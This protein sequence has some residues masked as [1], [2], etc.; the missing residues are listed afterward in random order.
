MNVDLPQQGDLSDPTARQC[1]V[2]AEPALPDSATIFELVANTAPV[3]I[4]V[5]GPDKLCRAA[6][7]AGIGERLGGWCAL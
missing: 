7:R 1:T 3:L 5:S 4:W 6:T 2:H